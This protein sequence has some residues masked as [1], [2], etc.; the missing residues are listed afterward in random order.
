MGVRLRGLIFSP[1]AS[2][3]L[4]TWEGEGGSER[5]GQLVVSD[6][7]LR[8][9]FVER[10]DEIDGWV[11]DSSASLIESRRAWMVMEATKEKRRKGGGERTWSA[12]VSG[13]RSEELMDFQLPLAMV[14]GDRKKTVRPVRQSTEPDGLK[15]KIERGRKGSGRKEELTVES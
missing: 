2:K 15:M 10:R 5:K 1:D 3:N 6:E 9:D 4:V 11:M 14:R 12:M 7:E 13:R 8:R